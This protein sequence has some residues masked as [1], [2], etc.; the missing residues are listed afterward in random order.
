MSNLEEHD[1]E[2][3][4]ITALCEAG[5]CD[6]PECKP[7]RKINFICSECGESALYWDSSVFWDVGEQDYRSSD[8][9]GDT[10]ICGDCGAED[11]EKAVDVETGEEL[12]QPPLGYEWVPIEQA[13]RAW[14]A[15]YARQ[16]ERAE[17]RRAELKALDTANLLA[18]DRDLG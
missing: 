3:A 7:K 5:E 12:K 16:S 17:A 2:Q 1:V 10:A 6:H 15:H 9:I 4:A 14:A 18:A 11:C 13:E 8:D